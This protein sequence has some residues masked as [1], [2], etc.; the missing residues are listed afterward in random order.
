MVRASGTD[1]T[2]CVTAW[3]AGFYSDKHIFKQTGPD[4]CHFLFQEER[5][6][7]Q[8]TFTRWRGISKWFMLLSKAQMR[9]C[10]CSDPKMTNKLFLEAGPHEKKERKRFTF[11]SAVEHSQV[12][13]YV[14]QY[15]PDRSATPLRVWM[16]ATATSGMEATPATANTD[17]GG[18]TVKKV[19]LLIKRNICINQ[20]HNSD[21][22]VLTQVQI[23]HWMHQETCHYSWCCLKYYSAERLMIICT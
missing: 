1:P 14:F 20:K 16:G 5:S 15:S 7:L 13:V 12:S 22:Y 23:H 11:P 10:I 3:A 9:I 2:T 6:H 8:F 19:A 17:T 4:K 21:V 18:S